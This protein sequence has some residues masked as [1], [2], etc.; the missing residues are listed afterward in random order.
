MVDG[1]FKRRCG[2]FPDLSFCI[3]DPL[4]FLCN[5]D[6]VMLQDSCLMLEI[7]RV[8]RRKSFLL[9]ETIS[10]AAAEIN[11]LLTDISVLDTKDSTV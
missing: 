4:L 10:I 5:Q 7:D 1:E 11:G 6:S 8:A 2:H 3:L 9:Q